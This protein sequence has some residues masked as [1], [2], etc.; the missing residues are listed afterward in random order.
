MALFKTLF[1]IIIL[2]LLSQVYGISQTVYDTLKSVKMVAVTDEQSSSITIQWQDDP[3]VNIYSLYKKSRQDTTWGT[4]LIVTGDQDTSYLDTD[5]EEGNLYEYQIIKETGNTLGYAYLL[6]GINYLPPQRRGNILLLVDSTAAELAEDNLNIYMNTLVSEGWLPSLIPVSVDAS[7]PE[8]KSLILENYS[9]LDSLT[10]VILMGNIVVPYSGNINPDGHINHKGAWPADVYYGDMDG[11]WTDETVNNTAAQFPRVHNIP[12]DGKFDQDSIPGELELAIGRLDFSELPNFNIDEYELLNNYLQKNIAFRTGQY[13][14]GRRAL[15]RNINPWSEGLG[16]NAIRNFVPLVSN[17]SIAY[18]EIFDAFDHP[19]LWSYFGSSGY[20]YGAFGLGDTSTFRDNN[21]QVTFTAFFGSTYGDYNFED[22]FLRTVLAS[23]KVLS[24]AWVGAPSWHFHPMGMGMDLG[25]C[26]LITQNNP[27]LYYPGVQEKYVTINLLGDPT[28]KAF[29]VRPPSNLN[30]VQNGNHNEL[31]WAHS[32]DNIL[33][34]QVYKKKDGMK[35]FEVMNTNP[36]S[37]SVFIDSCIVGES[38]IQYLVKA[39]KQEVSPSGSYINHSTG[40]IASIQT[41]SNI[42]PEA[43]FELSWDSNILTGVNLSENSNQ[44]Y[45]ILPD[46]SES[47]EDNFEIPFNQEGQ[48]SVTLITSNDCFSDTLQQFIFITDTKNLI[49]DNEIILYP[50]PTKNII[51]I[52]TSEYIDELQIKNIL[53]THI[54]TKSNLVPGIYKINLEEYGSRIF[55]L[56]FRVGTQLIPK[57]IFL[58]K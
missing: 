45:W 26:T 36:I 31:S 3:D 33:G 8:V 17:D 11:I 35:Y 1:R 23:G 52:E 55:L 25:F 53:G 13:Q 5:I 58:Q 15:F 54:L 9:T 40:P 27:E 46:G 44:N 56:N 10:A 4:P 47:T 49:E 20:M 12:G 57:M 29:I 14:A 38:L 28:L 30:V 22:N 18:D 24:T 21:F 37:D 41:T 6:S 16:Q 48:A 42:L 51:T 32:D 19:Y 7:V 2:L 39:V 50:N 43:D 34:Y